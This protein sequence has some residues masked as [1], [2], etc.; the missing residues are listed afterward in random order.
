MESTGWSI[1]RTKPTTKGPKIPLEYGALRA[2]DSSNLRRRDAFPSTFVEQDSS[3]RLMRNRAA[4]KYER[5]RRSG[6]RSE[7][8]RPI[9]LPGGD[10]G[11]PLAQSNRCGSLNNRLAS[12]AASP[13]R[14]AATAPEGR[15]ERRRYIEEVTCAKEEERRRRNERQTSRGDLKFIR[16][17]GYHSARGSSL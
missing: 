9:L 1:S 5:T 15:S 10:S 11:S 7:R 6:K 3:R 8:E 2:R 13:R 17:L 14:E 12:V 4:A 16:F